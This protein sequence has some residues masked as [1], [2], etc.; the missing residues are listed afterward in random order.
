MPEHDA[1]PLPAPRVS[2]CNEVVRDMP[3]SAQCDFAAAVGYDGLEIAPFTLSSEPQ[4]LNDRE[5]AAIRRA[6]SDAGIACTGLHWLLVAPAGLSITSADDAARARTIDV[7]ER[8]CELAAE[9][10]A[11]VLVHGSPAQRR[12][13]PEGAEARVRALGVLER[14]ARAAQRSGVT[15]C[16]EPLAP[17]ETD[18]VNTIAQAAEIVREIGNPHLRTMIDCSAAGQAETESVDALVRRWMPTGL[19]AH[20]QLNDPNRR[21]PGQGDMR[22]EPIIAA[23][24]DSGYAGDLAIEPFDYVPDGP[25]CAARAAGYVRGLLEAAIR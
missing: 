3:F 22:F 24:I 23:L 9:L 13:G 20:V 6:L 2:L 12:L 19:V 1:P 25:T 16:L 8:L 21:G 4:S 15:Y 18:F 7:I 11:R 10:G 17:R 14:A 5:I